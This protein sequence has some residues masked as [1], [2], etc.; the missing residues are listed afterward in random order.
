MN[1]KSNVV[2]VTVGIREQEAPEAD[3]EYST[4]N[5]HRLWNSFVKDNLSSSFMC[6]MILPEVGAILII[7]LLTD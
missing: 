5:G 2:S 4:G 6:V 3:L 7:Y 1:V